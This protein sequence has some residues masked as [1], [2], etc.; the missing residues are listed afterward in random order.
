MD[1]WV[2]RGGSRIFEKVGVH[3]RSKS[4]KERGVCP[5]GGPTLGPMLK[6]LHRG[7]K[8]GPPDP[9][10]GPPQFGGEVLLLPL[11]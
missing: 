2:I 4:K 5:G 3:F 8:R 11:P 9:P 6:N 1:G 7:P 10:M